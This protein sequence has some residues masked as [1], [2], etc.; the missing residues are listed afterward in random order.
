MREWN[1]LLITLAGASTRV[2]VNEVEVTRFREGDTVPSRKEEWEP[3]R[4]ARPMTGFI[5]LQNHGQHDLVYFRDVRVRSS[6]D[7][8]Q[9]SN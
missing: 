2:A 3:Q 9:R 4:A 6:N 8:N 1:D 5:G 7:P